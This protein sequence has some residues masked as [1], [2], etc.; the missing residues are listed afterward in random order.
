[1]TGITKDSE[2]SEKFVGRVVRQCCGG[3]TEDITPKAPVRDNVPVIHITHDGVRLE[4][5]T[6]D[7]VLTETGMRD[8]DKEKTEA[9]DIDHPR[10][11]EP[12]TVSMRLHICST[13]SEL[14]TDDQ[15]EP[16]LEPLK[17][18][19]DGHT[20]CGDPFNSNTLTNPLRFGC[21]CDVERRAQWTQAICPRK[22]WG[23]GRRFESSILPVHISTRQE[24]MPATLDYIGPASIEG[25]TAMDYSG[26]G[27][28][29]QQGVIAQALHRI[30]KA[31]GIN[32][33]FTTV[34]QR[35]AWGE[36]ACGMG[37]EV[38]DI[39]D[40]KRRV[41][42]FASHSSSLR[43]VEMDAT[44]EMHG[45]SRLQFVAKQFDIPFE[46]I[47]HWDVRLHN[48]QEQQALEF[49]KVPKREGRP[50]A[51]VV[52]FANASM[53]Q[54]PLRHFHQ[55]IEKLK[56][57]GLAVFIID[58]PRPKGHL[59]YRIPVRR[60]QSPDP[61]M[62]A[63]VIKH[64]DIVIGNDSGM[65]HLTGW[66]GSKAL[67]ICGVTRGSV[68]FG[69]WPTVEP[70]QAPGECSGCSYFQDNGWKPWCSWGCG[71]MSDLKP[72]DVEM[73]VLGALGK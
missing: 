12:S 54:W 38:T 37:I 69:G 22:L 33:R 3:K 10:R 49:L 53:R 55:L 6:V 25:G 5:D 21:G 4:G 71:L 39:T 35:M 31:Q 30:N 45:W 67:A 24:P 26:I 66:V 16:T 59:V 13:C 20:Y 50:I 27:D 8:L 43:M 28:T 7:R 70:I 65:Q 46:E 58:A 68:V 2:G 64:S 14:V 47:K 32:V 11:A 57:Q 36:L 56:K 42:E 19:V 34:P 51:A 40:E 17:R 9:P 23:P 62:V 52:P 41:G 61:H 18:V 72:R 44:C 29:M 73:R 60:M 63:S 48:E 1:V 15:G